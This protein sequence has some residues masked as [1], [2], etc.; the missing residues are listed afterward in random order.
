MYF[1]GVVWVDR[2][3]KKTLIIGSDALTVLLPLGIVLLLPKFNDGISLRVALLVLVSLRSIATGVQITAASDFKAD[4]REGI[5]YSI[6][7]RPIG[8]ILLLYGLFISL[9]IPAGFLANLF[10]SRYFGGT[11]K[12]LM[13][14]EIVGFGGMLAGGLLMSTWGDFKKT[15]PDDGRRFGLIRHIQH[16]Q[17]SY[18]SVA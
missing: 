2:H 1:A 13:W 7:T 3:S 14:V 15:F 17:H 9:F 10:V 5:R 6:A 4:V 8:G 18:G 16:I 12:N 11:Y